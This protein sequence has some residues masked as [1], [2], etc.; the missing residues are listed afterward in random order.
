MAEKH[1]A[2]CAICGSSYY[3]CLS[4]KDMMN[5]NPWKRHTDTSE[6]YKIY[7]ILRGR[8]TGVYTKDEAKA[9]LQT[10]DLSDF[11]NL[12]CNIKYAISEIMR[13][14]KVNVDEVV[15]KEIEVE[16]VVLDVAESEKPKVARRR[17]SSKV[18]ETEK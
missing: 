4:C 6:H 18:V 13:E 1:N 9:K 16:T 14:D 10:I 8:N 12:R 3:M 2:T 7:Q 11:D 15:D 17:K 5:L